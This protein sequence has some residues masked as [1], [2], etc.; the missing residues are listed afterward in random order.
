LPITYSF[1]HWESQYH[2]IL[3]SSAVA[4]ANFSVIA[5][6]TITAVYIEIPIPPAQGA[7]LP[8]AFSPNGDGNNDV[9]FVYGGQIERISIAIYNRWGELVWETNDETEGWDGTYEGKEAIAGVYV[10]KLKVTY[11]EGD[12]ENK[13]GN[14]TL[15]R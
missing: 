11:W 6:D 2:T 8:G 13:S 5:D 3:P 7:H 10:Y 1:D 12:I 14:I 15:I 4:L 9:L